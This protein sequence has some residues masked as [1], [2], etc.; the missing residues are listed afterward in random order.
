M[1]VCSLRERCRSKYDN[2]NNDNAGRP[3]AIM[4]TTTTTTTTM[5]TMTTMT[6]TTTMT[7]ITTRAQRAHNFLALHPLQLNGKMSHDGCFS[8]NFNA[9]CDF[10]AAFPNIGQGNCYIFHVVVG[11]NPSGNG[12]A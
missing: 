12:E 9:R 3:E 8:N 1:V 11:I 7:T 6:T 5:T 2:S 4:T 10:I